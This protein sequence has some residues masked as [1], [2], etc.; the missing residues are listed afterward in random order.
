MYR[1][2]NFS[3]F[4]AVLLAGL[5]LLFS[6]SAQTISSKIVGS[7]VD[8]SQLPVAGATLVLHEVSTGAER[9]MQTDVQGNFVFSNLDPGEYTLTAEASGFKKLE[10]K[11]LMLSASETLPAGTLALEVGSVTQE[12]TV[13]AAGSVVQTASTERSGVI[14]SSQVDDLL[15]K[16]RNAMSLVFLIAGVVDTSPE[17][18][19]LTRTWSDAVQGNRQDT[20]SLTIDGM[21]QNSW[22]LANAYDVAVSQDSIAEVKVLVGNYQAEYGGRSGAAITLVSKTGSK[23]F[24]GLFSWFKRNEEFNANNFFNNRTGVPKP[25]YRYNTW[26]YNIGGPIY[27]PRH[28]NRS[29]DKLFFFWSQ[30][31]WPQQVGEIGDLTVPTAL[32]RTGDFSQTVGLNG[33]LIPITDPTTHAPFPGNIVPASRINASGQALMDMFPLPNF[34]N[35]SVSSGNYNYIYD[36]SVSNPTNMETLKLDYYINPKHRISGSYYR[37][38]NKETGG[39]G[40]PVTT[41]NWPLFTEYYTFRGTTYLGRY[42]AIISPTSVNELTIGYTN[43]PQSNGAAP[44]QVAL[45]NRQNVGFAAGQFNPQIN[46]L[47]LIPSATFGG[48]LPNPANLYIEGRFPFYQIGDVPSITDTITKIHGAHTFKAGMLVEYLAHRASAELGYPWGNFDFTRNTVN[49]LDTNYPYSNAVLGIFNTYQESNIQPEVHFRQL[50]VEWFAQDSWKVSRRLTLEIG[51]R[52]SHFDPMWDGRN[53]LAGFSTAAFNPSQEVSLIQPEIV[54][55]V[56]VGVNPL[57]GATSPATTIGAIAPGSGNFANGMVVISQN[58]SYPRGLYNLPA[59]NLGPRFGFAYDVFGTGKTAVRGGFGMFYNNVGYN[60][61][62]NL[63]LQPPLVET[64][65]VYYGQLSTFLSSSGT[66]FPQTVYGVGK[67]QDTPMV[68]NM[69]LSIQQKLPFGVILDVGYA[70]SLARHL[71]WGQ[72]MDPVPMGAQ[73]NPA[74]QDPTEPGT[75]LSTAFLTPIRGYTGIVEYEAAGSSSY[76]SLQVTANRRFAHGLQFG[77]AWTWSKAMDFEDTD[78]G[79]ISPFESP[80]VYNY[81]PAGFDRTHVLNMSGIWEIPGP[82]QNRVLKQVFNGW[83]LSAMPSFV[84]GAPL[85]ISFTTVAGTNFTGTPTQ[86]ARVNVVQNPLLSKSQRTFSRNFNTQAFAMPAVGTWGNEANTEIRG[87]GINNFD[88]GLFKN[89]TVRER[90]RLQL[91]GE[92]YNAFN[93]TQFSSLNTTAQFNAAGAQVNAQ[94]G[95]FTAAREARIMQLALRASF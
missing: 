91:R 68:M 4:L 6:L 55:G 7:V 77:A 11:G 75:A 37:Y 40:L 52:F 42:T 29:K 12:V 85:G 48:G 56:R 44:D 24:H 38:Y 57:T 67:N 46:K 35:R 45:V 93:H 80:R 69:S 83:Q 88:I 23:D 47:D 90:F 95:A 8:P 72:Q 82:T 26:T 63:E 16:S 36:T 2:R 54:N 20:N 43:R 25:R 53:F 60:I 76:H 70:G 17:Q 33:Q 64:P 27:I 89:I 49:P 9:K 19:T 87:P 32:E 1:F 30:E 79:V 84:S 18:D 28:F 21:T 71:F 51:L 3:S 50:Q 78:T 22:G 15:T 41:S 59:V 65:E 66:L 61:Y 62:S 58:P 5:G 39:V 73:F 74:N 31:F 86:G 81:G 34:T 92:A 94:F 10:Q 13:A 14:Q